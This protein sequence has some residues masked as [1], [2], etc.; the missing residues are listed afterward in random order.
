V[1]VHGVCGALGTLLVGVFAQEMYGG[2]NGLLFGGGFRLLG[3]QSLGVGAVLLWTV[4]ASFILFGTIKYLFGLRVS[5]EDELKGLDIAEH[6]AEAYAD[7]PMSAD[8]N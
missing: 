5:T 8:S 1:S 7:F 6:G 4:S 3:I 2:V